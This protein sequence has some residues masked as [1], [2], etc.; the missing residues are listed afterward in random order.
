[1]STWNALECA[2]LQ[3]LCGM[4]GSAGPALAAQ[5]SVAR[6][7]DRRNSGCGFFTYF[8]VPPEAAPP[9]ACEGPIGT[10]WVVIEGFEHPMLLLLFLENGYASML[11]GATVGDVTTG[12]DFAARS[13]GF[14]AT[15]WKPH[16]RVG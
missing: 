13:Y 2:V 16:G 4:A 8:D 6:I 15:D 14:F 11:E 12:V 10:T 3:E 9:V 5:L 1:M 7:S